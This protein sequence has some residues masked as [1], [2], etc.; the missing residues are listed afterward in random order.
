[1][2]YSASMTFLVYFVI[3][4]LTLQFCF[5]IW[6]KKFNCVEPNKGIYKMVLSVI[7]AGI[8]LPR[9]NTYGKHWLDKTMRVYAEADVRG[10]HS[11]FFLSTLSLSLESSLSLPVLLL[12]LCT[13]VKVVVKVL[14]L[15]M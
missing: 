4:L 3:L 14:L 15:F 6:R 9:D 1:M 12:T 8:K 11:S 5:R 10:M 2:Q 7:W 13:D